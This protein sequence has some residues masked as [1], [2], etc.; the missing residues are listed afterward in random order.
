MTDANILSNQ[1]KTEFLINIILK[2]KP[3]PLRKHIMYMLLRPTSYAIW[4]TTGLLLEPN[5]I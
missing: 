2:I 4:G 1:I 3:V 5:E